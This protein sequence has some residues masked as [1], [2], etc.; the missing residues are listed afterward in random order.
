MGNQHIPICIYPDSYCF[1]Y[2][3]AGGIDMQVAW[4]VALG[5]GYTSIVDLG[6]KFIAGE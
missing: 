4:G 2:G 1:L 3:S 5:T 6:R